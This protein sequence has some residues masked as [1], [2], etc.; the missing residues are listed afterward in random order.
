MT[1]L[2]NKQFAAMLPAAIR[3]SYYAP[4]A[5][6]PILLC[7]GSMPS[8]EVIAG[9]SISSISSAPISTQKTGTI[10]MTGSSISL[11]DQTMPPQWYMDTCPTANS[12]V[13]TQAGTIGWAVFYWP[14]GS[15]LFV[16]D[17]SLPNQGGCVQL[18][19]TAVAVGDTVS[20]LG[21]SFSMWR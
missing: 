14:R 2:A 1:M 4:S 15:T 3:Y 9:M 21:L 16:M 11:L 20:L 6:T 18:D 17:V 12:C 19:K 13:V 7:V 8:D 10:V 5:N